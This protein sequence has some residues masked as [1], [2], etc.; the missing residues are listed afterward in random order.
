MANDRPDHPFLARR[1]GTI[2]AGV[3][4]RRNSGCFCEK[5]GHDRVRRGDFDL[6]LELPDNSQA[7]GGGAGT[8][9]RLLTGSA[10][11][12]ELARGAPYGY[13]EAD[14]EIFAPLAR[15]EAGDATGA[16]ANFKTS[17]KPW[18]LTDL[19]AMMRASFGAPMW[20]ELA[21]RCL[22][23]GNCTIVCPLC[24]CFYTRDE[25][26]LDPTSGRRLRLWDSCQLVAFARVA[27]GH[28]FR[29]ARS[30]RIWYR[31]SHKFMRTQEA[32]GRPGCSGCGACFHF[33][34]VDIDP[35]EVI[36]S[37]MEVTASA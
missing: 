15:K 1:D 31:F 17:Y 5:T 9:P 8:G 19:P 27:G 7:A 37:V 18:P 11:G 3:S 2:V 23:C 21:A 28:N 36:A 6:F 24:Y 10:A 13:G 25:T 32:L 29:E 12:Q 20:E 14:E 30:E 26:G 34:P 33:C 4:C 16:R 35:R 22:G